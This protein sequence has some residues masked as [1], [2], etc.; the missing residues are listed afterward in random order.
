MFT[1]GASQPFPFD[2]PR[3]RLGTTLGV[4][5]VFPATRRTYGLTRNNYDLIKE[6]KKLLNVRHGFLGRRNPFCFLV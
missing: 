6:K 3:P 2:R 1:G 5:S 4:G